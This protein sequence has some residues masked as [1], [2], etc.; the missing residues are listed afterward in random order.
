MADVQEIRRLRENLQGEIDGAVVYEAMAEAEAD[1][2]VAGVYRELARTERRHAAY[3]AEKLGQANGGTAPAEPKP[4]PRAR[5]M[6]W[7]SR[8]FG[9]SSVLP[10]LSAAERRDSRHYDDQP[11]AVANNFHRDER[12]HARVVQAA[13]SRNG[14]LPGETLARLEGRHAGG[15]GNA[16]RAAVLGANDGLVSNLSLVMGV[17]GAAANSTIILLTGLAGLVAGS[18]SMAMGEWLSVNSSRELAQKQIDSEAKELAD[19]PDL[20][21]EE[22]V[23]IYQAKGLDEASARDMAE[24]I[25]ESH[26]AALDTL[27]REELGVDPKELGG[28]AWA[29]AT[30]SFCLFAFGAVFPV[31]PFLFASGAPAVIASIA[32]SGIVLCAIGA[33]TSLFTGRGLVFSAVRQLLIGWAAAAVTFGVGRLLGVAV[34]G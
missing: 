34:Q 14:G 26:D 24:R 17:T 29:A 30:A 21:K 23:L 18:C 33:A 20:E 2:H 9:P 22:L 12:M 3:W 13:A 32:L 19:A 10:A 5:L 4:T 6:A 1:P 31:A 16:L 15:G 11:D 28:S 27:A 25:F 7:A 8:R